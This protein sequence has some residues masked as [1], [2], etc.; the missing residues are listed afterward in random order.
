MIF[1]R[2]KLILL[3]AYRRNVRLKLFEQASRVILE[4][5]P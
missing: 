5:A 1:S 2:R 4:D 3:T